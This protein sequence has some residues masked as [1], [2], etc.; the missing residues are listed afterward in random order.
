MP[1]GFGVALWMRGGDYGLTLAH[2]PWQRAM[3]LTCLTAATY[4]AVVLLLTSAGLPANGFILVAALYPT[5]DVTL[6]LM[7]LSPLICGYRVVGSV[8]LATALLGAAASDI[9]YLMMK[10]NPETELM[11]AAAAL[12]YIAFTIILAIY[13]FIA[14]RLPPRP[15]PILRWESVTL[16]SVHESFAAG[17]AVLAVVFGLCLLHADRGSAVGIVGTCV[18]V[19]TVT[20]LAARVAL[21]RSR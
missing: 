7:A 12:G 9:G 17:C 20:A 1:V 14:Q 21:G 13:A 3:T 11:P 8:V 4:A 15:R 19:V 6:A 2:R 16:T 5:G 18:I 10:A